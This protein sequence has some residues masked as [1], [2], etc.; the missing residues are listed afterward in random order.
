MSSMLV[1]EDVLVTIQSIEGSATFDDTFSILRHFVEKLG[2]TSLLIGRVVNPVIT[3]KAITNFGRSDWPIEYLREWVEKDYVIHDP[4]T[5]L[6][7]RTSDPFD[8]SDAY[9][10]GS[11]F[12]K[13]I[14]ERAKDFGLE[15]GLSIPIRTNYLPL[16]VVSIGYEEKFSDEALE[17]IELAATHAYTHAQSLENGTKGPV[18]VPLTKRELEVLTFTAAGKT[19]WEISVILDVSDTTIKSHVRNIITKMETTNKTH[20]VIKGVQ[21]GQIIL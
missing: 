6:A 12:G 11:S 1:W 16:G 21:S 14:L 19:T 3:G 9:E 4:I 15:S 17:H 20:A 18:P 7:L 10:Q 2:G 8:W 5:H 13:K